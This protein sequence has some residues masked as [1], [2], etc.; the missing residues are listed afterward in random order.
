MKFNTI[1]GASVTGKVEEAG[2]D[3]GEATVQ[4][5]CYHLKQNNIQKVNNANHSGLV[6]MLKSSTRCVNVTTHPTC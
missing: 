5:K 4:L 2:R 6:H 3:V 1:R